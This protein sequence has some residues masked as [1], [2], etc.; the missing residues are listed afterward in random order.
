MLSEEGENKS[1]AA[2]CPS[3]TPA[4]VSSPC[5]YW[6]LCMHEVCYY[7]QAFANSLET[8]TNKH[9]LLWWQLSGITIRRFSFVYLLYL[10]NMG[11][12]A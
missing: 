2:P 6:E 3:E 9:L 4:L 1:R 5:L 8:S 11:Y 10:L 12:L 7:K